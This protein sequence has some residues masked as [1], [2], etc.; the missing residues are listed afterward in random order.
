MI[1]NAFRRVAGGR[2]PT[3]QI[4]R[5]IRSYTTEQPL[6]GEARI[7]QKLTESFKPIRLQVEDVS[8]GCG[9]FYAINIAS[10]S[11][12]GLTTV[13]QHRLVNETLK[14]DIAGIHGLQVS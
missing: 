9:S 5:S 3:T 11:F 10:D 14:E 6:A 1:I 12:K 2:Q 7:R 13:K 4:S 8:G